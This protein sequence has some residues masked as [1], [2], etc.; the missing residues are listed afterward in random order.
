MALAERN[1]RI[2][3]SHSVEEAEERDLDKRRGRSRRGRSG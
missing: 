1:G 2:R 3:E